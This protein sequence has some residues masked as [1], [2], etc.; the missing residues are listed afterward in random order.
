[1]GN[2]GLDEFA[3]VQTLSAKFLLA[4]NARIDKRLARVGATFKLTD[5]VPDESE[6]DIHYPGVLV[7]GAA[8]GGFG[9]ALEGLS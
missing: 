2:T 8:F 1:V 9:P 5:P 6:P 4:G 3:A 7:P